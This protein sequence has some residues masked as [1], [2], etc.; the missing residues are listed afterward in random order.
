MH[1]RFTKTGGADYVLPHN[2]L[3]IDSETALLDRR[4]AADIRPEFSRTSKTA[5]VSRRPVRAIIRRCFQRGCK[6]LERWLR[7]KRKVD[8]WHRIMIKKHFLYQTSARV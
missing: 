2:D 3:K 1:A 5:G 8:L 4:V 6:V 7:L